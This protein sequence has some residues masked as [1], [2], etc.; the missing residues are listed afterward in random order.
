MEIGLDKCDQA[1]FLKGK[2]S[3]TRNISQERDNEI[4]G[5]EPEVSYMHLAVLEREG[6]K[7]ASIRKYYEK[8]VIAM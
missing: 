6:I 2:L 1:T 5:L 7:N 4:K 8:S 3:G